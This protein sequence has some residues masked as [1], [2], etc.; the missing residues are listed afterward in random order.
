MLPLTRPSAR[1]TALLFRLLADPAQIERLGVGFGAGA[2]PMSAR[3]IVDASA[4]ITARLMHVLELAHVAR[5]G[6]RLDRG[7]RVGQQRH[8]AASLLG[9]EAPH[10]RV[11]EQRGV[12][13]PRAQRRDVDDDLRQPVV[14]VLAE[15]SL[16]DQRPSGP[17]AS[18]RRRAR[19]PGSPRARRRARSRAPAGSAA[20]SPA[21]PAAG[22]R[23]RPGTA[24]RGVRGLDLA[25]SSVCAA[26]V[27]APFS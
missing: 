22:R 4:M 18:R 13:V 5:P 14:Q 1:V 11:R 19:R 6:M 9:G 21:A 3:V 10:E 8:R 25:R 16:A 23:S 20:A 15:A 2:R 17:G 7:D 27:N 12:A 24:C 26:P